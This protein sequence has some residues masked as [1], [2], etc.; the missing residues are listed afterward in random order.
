MN[1]VNVF[2]ELDAPFS[3]LSLIDPER[4]EQFFQTSNELPLLLKDQGHKILEFDSVVQTE[5]FFIS[6]FA[7]NLPFLNT[8]FDIINL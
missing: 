4:F 6:G 3:S 8:R 7:N 1:S 5:R 2:I